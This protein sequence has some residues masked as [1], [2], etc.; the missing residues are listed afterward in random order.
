[1]SQPVGQ[2]GAGGDAEL[3]V[4]A[5]EVTLDGLGRDE[6]LR[7]DL[8][9]LQALGDELGLPEIGR[10]GVSPDR[11]A[12]RAASVRG[13]DP[14]AERPGGVSCAARSNNSVAAAGAPRETA[15]RPASSSAAATDSSAT[16]GV[17]AVAGSSCGGDG[18]RSG[19][20]ALRDRSY[21]RAPGAETGDLP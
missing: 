1:M 12:Q 3:A 6:E 9:G 7:G 13:R 2:L 14:S 18:S 5:G 10:C 11:N 8:F 15:R 21:G 17:S 4:D 19:S 16:A 20:S